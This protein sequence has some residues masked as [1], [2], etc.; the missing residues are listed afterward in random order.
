MPQVRVIQRLHHHS[1]QRNPF[2][3]L[4]GCIG[5]RDRGGIDHYVIELCVCVCVCVCVRACVRAHVCV[6]VCMYDV[7]VYVCVREREEVGV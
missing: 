2:D 6:C 4:V 7:C 5:G 3:H 1:I